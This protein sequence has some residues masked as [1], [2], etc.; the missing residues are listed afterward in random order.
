MLTVANQKKGKFSIGRLTV[1]FGIA[2]IIEK[3]SGGAN[4]LNFLNH[5][6]LPSQQL[7]EVK[8][9]WRDSDKVGDDIQPLLDRHAAGDWG[10][11]CEDDKALN[12]EAISNEAN[13]TDPDGN[14]LRGRVMSSYVLHGEKVW[15]I[16]EYDRSET[17][18]LLPDEY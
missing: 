14:D 9:V 3:L 15:V 13:P 5:F 17:T 8:Y 18:V 11:L 10:D 2:D 16:T 7:P 6:G 12:N 1:T 4:T